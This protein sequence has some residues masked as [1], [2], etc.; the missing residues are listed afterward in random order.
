VRLSANPPL[1]SVQQKALGKAG[2]SGSEDK[3][4]NTKVLLLGA[5]ICLKL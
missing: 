1:P 2:D 4:N 3:I 5:I